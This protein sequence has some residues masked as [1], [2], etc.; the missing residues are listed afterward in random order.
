[1]AYS[2]SDVGHVRFRSQNWIEWFDINLPRG[3]RDA[4]AI[5]VIQPKGDNNS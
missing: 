4:R 2:L 1:M 5:T 3:E